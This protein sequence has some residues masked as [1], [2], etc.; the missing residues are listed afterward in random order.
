G[1]LKNMIVGS[2]GENIY[3]EE[4][5][6]VINT[7][8]YVLESLVME[9][10]GRLVA[11][12]HLNYEEIEEHFAHLKEEAIQYVEQK[13]GEILRDLH[14]Y[15]NANV[16]RFSQLAAVHEQRMP[17]EKTATQKIKRYLYLSA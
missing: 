3:P 2:G 14:A 9:K 16:N 5:E 10:K 1:R 12:V 8:R 7:H 13:A 6:S 15:V 11:F 4:I 17:F